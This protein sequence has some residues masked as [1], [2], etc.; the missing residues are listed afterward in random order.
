[1]GAF[2]AFSLGNVEAKFVTPSN[3]N[4]ASYS[5]TR[6]QLQVGSLAG[7]V[8]PRKGNKGA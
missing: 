5:S 1:M 4:D 6:E 8:R 2:E 7:V 3:V